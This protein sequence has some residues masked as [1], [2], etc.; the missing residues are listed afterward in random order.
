MSLMPFGDLSALLGGIPGIPGMGALGAMG[1]L[2]GGG[3][4]PT[5][6]DPENPAGYFSGFTIAVD[7]VR[8]PSL[9]GGWQMMSLG[10]MEMNAN[11]LPAGGYMR[12]T[13]R[14]IERITT[15]QYL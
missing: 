12:T 2:G 13:F 11:D 7:A 9:G 4:G 1:G 8:D 10:S 5:R 3:F 15:G 6:W 14:Q